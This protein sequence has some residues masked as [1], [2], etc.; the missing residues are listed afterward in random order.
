MTWRSLMAALAVAALTCTLF[1]STSP[2]GERAAHTLAAGPGENAERRRDTAPGE[3]PEAAPAAEPG[4]TKATSRTSDARR[5]GAETAPEAGSPE[6]RRKKPSGGGET[7]TGRSCR[8]GR[9][10]RGKGRSRGDPAKPSSRSHGGGRAGEP[11]GDIPVPKRSGRA[12]LPS[13]RSKRIARG[14]TRPAHAQE[15]EAAKEFRRHPPAR[16]SRQ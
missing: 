16:R 3:A 1:G 11:S 13:M 14:V 7:D 2:C 15:V 10:A 12:P 9:E 5:Q 6:A 8:R 4:T